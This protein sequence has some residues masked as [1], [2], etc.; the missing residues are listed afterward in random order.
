VRDPKLELCNVRIISW[1][2]SAKT[3]IPDV[4]LSCSIAAKSECND[5]VTSI[6]A[7]INNTF[8]IIDNGLNEIDIK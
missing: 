5:R 8:D 4:G 1:P 6:A 2:W 3:S 7:D